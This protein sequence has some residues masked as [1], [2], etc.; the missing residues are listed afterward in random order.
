MRWRLV[1]AGC[2]L[3]RTAVLRAAAALIVVAASCILAHAA[4]GAQ[5]A[6]AATGLRPGSSQWYWVTFACEF[7]CGRRVVPEHHEVAGVLGAMIGGDAVLMFLERPPTGLDSLPLEQ[8]LALRV[9]FAADD[10]ALR[11]VARIIK[12]YGKR[13]R[14]A[15]NRP[16]DH[17]SLR[18]DQGTLGDLLRLLS[19]YGEVE[20]AGWGAADRT[21]SNVPTRDTPP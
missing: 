7:R 6:P 16:D 14:F 4:P 1:A 18:L 8:V 21:A 2:G 5:D 13:I 11:R 15:P 19:H 17:V 3:P 9:T 20:L 10:A 12:V